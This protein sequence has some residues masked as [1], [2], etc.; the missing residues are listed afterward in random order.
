[1]D[2]ALVGC[3]ATLGRTAGDGSPLRGECGIIEAEIVGLGREVRWPAVPV[4]EGTPR[5]PELGD[6][7]QQARSY[8]GWRRELIDEPL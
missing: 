2:L 7:F 4:R 8:F 1:M 6:G 5:C 3:S